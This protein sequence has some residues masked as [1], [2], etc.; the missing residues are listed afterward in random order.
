MLYISRFVDD[1]FHIIGHMACEQRK[2]SVT[3]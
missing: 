1:G 3:A 2:D